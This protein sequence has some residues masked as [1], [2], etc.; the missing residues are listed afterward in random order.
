MVLTKEGV[1]EIRSQLGKLPLFDASVADAKKE[2]DAEITVGI[3]VPV[4]KDYSGG[5]THERHKK[6]FLIMQKAGVLYQILGE[7]KYAVYVRDML[8]A[9]AKLY[10]TLPLH[11]QTRSY[12]R[13]KLFWQALNDS[14]WLVYV[15]QAYDCVYDFITPSDRAILERD[16]FKPFADFIS[17]GSPQFFNRVHNHSTWGNVA[18]GMIGLVMQDN[19]LVDRALNGLEN[20]GLPE[21]MK[22]SDGGLIRKP[23]Q[24]TG[25]LANVDEPF[26]P[27]GYYTEGPYY[28]RYAMYPFMVFAESLQNVRPDL[29][30]FDHKNGI[31]IKAVYALLNLTNSD[32]EFFPLNDG[33]KG[34]SYYS[35][36][37]VSAVDIAYLYGGKDPSLL[38]IAEKQG[39]VELDNSG[40]A[41]A[42]GVK[43]NL[44]K[45]FEKKSIDLS[46]GPE[47][48]DGGVAIIRNKTDGNELTLVMKY[49]SQGLSHGHY[50]KLSF[51][52]YQ[53]NKEILQD[54]GL[55]RFVNI[56]QKGGGNYLK[57]NTTWAKQTI[58]HNT[59][60]QNETSHFGADFET[61]NQFSSKKYLYD[62][63]NPKVQ[64][65]SATENNAYPGTSIHRTMALIQDEG[66]EKPYL[67]DIIQL[68]SKTA[69]Q[70][71]LPFYY[72]G[73]I[74]S[75]NFAYEKSKTLEPFGKSFGYQ[76]LWK[77]GSA[78]LNT[79]NAKV[80]WMNEGSF[81]T[82]TSVTKPND[83]LYFVR[84]GANDPNFNLRRDPGIVFRKKNAQ[85]ATFVSVLETHGSYS[86]VSEFAKNAYST[87]E[88][89]E[90]VYEDANYISVAIKTKPGVTSLFILATKNNKATQKHRLEINKKTYNW[91]GPYYKTTIK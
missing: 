10:P 38:S 68:N 8:M 84:T 43:N 48:K 40:M 39:R 37:L 30:I 66:F 31:L 4:P 46:D 41:V 6:N 15:S 53:N 21:G 58:A 86:T 80:S 13:G 54:Y 55:A 57:E 71:D 72:F 25:F 79:A 44:Q 18:V 24:K 51:S 63:T 59:I 61:G 88:S 60:I 19:E 1:R 65:I 16:L 76:H 64:I 91:V 83:E 90:L 7:E 73:Q 56:E 29:K 74:M 87:I 49:A 3:E 11:P 78:V 5:Y 22:D 23:G 2:V 9:Y 62:V 26:S 35:R 12:A 82:L 77:E 14:N 47:G 50:D 17:I 36:E 81:Y 42:L 45:P 75:A 32:G 89:V 52:Y 33:Q 28:Q 85:K 20:D 34:M 69:N 70:Y 27:D 67:L